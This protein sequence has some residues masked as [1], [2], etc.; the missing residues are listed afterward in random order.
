MCR[1]L[2][3]NVFATGGLSLVLLLASAV[4]T[5]ALAYQA[6]ATGRSHRALAETVLHDYADLA[7]EEFVRRATTYIG[8]Y[9][10]AMAIRGLAD[11]VAHDGALPA[12]QSLAAAIPPRS[13][14]AAELVGGMFRQ[15]GPDGHLEARDMDVPRDLGRQLARLPL[16]AAGEAAPQFRLV[17]VDDGGR[18]RLF[19]VA[20]E[21]GAGPERRLVGFEARLDQVGAWLSEHALGD[22]LLPQA[23]VDRGAT[24]ASMTVVV[25]S[26]TGHVVFSS[27]PGQGGDTPLAVRDMGERARSGA[28]PGF[29]VAVAMAPSAADRLVIGGL[30][31]SRTGWLIGLFALCMGLFLAALFQFRREQRH[32][33]AREDFIARASHEL[34]T[35]V[36]RIRMFAE[37][38]LLDRVRS[39]EERKS[40]LQALDRAARRLS[41]LVDN[42]LQFSRRPGNREEEQDPIPDE[43]VDVAALAREVVDEFRSVQGAVPPIELVAGAGIEARIGPDA[44]RQVLLNLLDNACKYGGA[45]PVRIRLC[46]D[47]GMARLQVDD[48]GPGVPPGD[49]ERIWRP[50]FRLDRDR[51]SAV[52]GTGIGLAVVGEL[53][54]RHGGRCAVEDAPGGGARFVVVLPLARE[55]ERATGAA[56]P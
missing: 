44:F 51:R 37:T 25:R 53:V 2:A 13:R 4:L 46:E 18:P 26:R 35:P 16:A 38:L 24:E 52:S 45:A 54:S 56:R 31:R 22:P 27:H 42:V 21:R 41:L 43:R 29:S 15:S 14:R 17:E 8:D 10:F 40:A 20:G 19:V 30:P 50:Y 55:S 32:A 28:L 12:P 3:R 6:L 33:L 49:R 7:A 47:A 5:I 1:S 23:L 48:A 39:D 9:G 11:T 34:R 36:T